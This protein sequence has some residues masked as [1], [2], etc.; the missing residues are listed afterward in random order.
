MS[1]EIK[2]GKIYQ[3]SRKNEKKFIPNK[4]F[5][6]LELE[7]STNSFVFYNG[8]Y[9]YTRIPKD[10]ILDGS[11]RFGRMVG[12]T[13]ECREA[14]KKYYRL[15]HGYKETS[16]YIKKTTEALADLKEHLVDIEDSLINLTNTSLGKENSN[17]PKEDKS[18]LLS[19]LSKS[20]ENTMKY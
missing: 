6:L 1:S 10:D 7:T 13:Q 14:F 4:V 9:T 18:R 15:Y 19:S 16:E 20:T 17:S 3:L 8:E 5:I 2:K 11:V 12:L